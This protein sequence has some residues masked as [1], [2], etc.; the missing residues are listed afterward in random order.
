VTDQE[1]M[2]RCK[3][4]DHYLDLLGGRRFPNLSPAERYRIA[5]LEW[6]LWDVA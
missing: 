1:Q 4:L 3:E 6:R 2:A 5:F